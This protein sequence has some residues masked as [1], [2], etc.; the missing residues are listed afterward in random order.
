MNSNLVVPLKNYL[1]EFDQILNEMANGMLTQRTENSISAYFIVCMIPHHQA[2]IYMCQNLLRFTSDISLKRIATNI[3]QTQ[4]KGIVQMNEIMQTLP[5]FQNTSMDTNFYNN[6]FYTITTAMI[7]QMVSSKRGSSI[8]LNFISEM[9]PH[10]EGAI[11]M[12]QNLIKYPIDPRLYKV[13]IHIIEEQSK[14]VQE[15]KSLQ[16]QLPH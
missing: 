16:E 15:L 5:P 6:T 3:I 7:T 14:G 8:D 1:F 4:T 10:H 11:E 12:C 2:A 9:I 13:A